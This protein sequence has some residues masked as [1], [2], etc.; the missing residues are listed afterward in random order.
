MGTE[1]DDDGCR[2]PNHRIHQLDCQHVTT[3]K[4]V[5]SGNQVN[6]SPARALAT[7]NK[8]IGDSL[9]ILVAKPSLELGEAK[10][11]VGNGVPAKKVLAMKCEDCGSDNN[12]R[13]QGG[14]EQSQQKRPVNFSVISVKS[15]EGR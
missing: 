2:G 8:L 12:S 3:N 9:V 10:K 1:V 14:N 13:E 15:G 6:H 11:V 4:A 5:D 7:A